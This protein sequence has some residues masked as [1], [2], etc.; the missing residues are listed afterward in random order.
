LSPGSLADAASASLLAFPAAWCRCFFAL[1]A[2]RVER[3]GE[4]DRVQGSGCSA[5]RV[6]GSGRRMLRIQGP[7]SPR[8]GAVA[9]LR[10][11]LLRVQASGFRA[12]LQASGFRAF[13]PAAQGSG[14][15]VQGIFVLARLPRGLVP[16]LLRSEGCSYEKAI[17]P[18][19]LLITYPCTAHCLCVCMVG[20]GLF[21]VPRGRVPLLLRAEGCSGFVF[22]A[23]RLVYH[24]A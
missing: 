9:S 22:E 8:P 23:H 2:A 18:P 15:R 17:Q 14:F 6:Q 24:S 3:E 19:L 4:R 20:S 10:R 13:Y 11:K 7:P 12:F 21:S 5:F 16:L 1:K